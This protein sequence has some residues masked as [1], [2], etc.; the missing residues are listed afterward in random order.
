MNIANGPCRN[1]HRLIRPRGNGQRAELPADQARLRRQGN[2][3]QQRPGS[4]VCLRDNLSNGPLQRLPEGIDPHVELLVQFHPRHQRLGH[5]RVQLRLGGG[6]NDKQGLAR[7][8][9]VTGIDGFTDQAPAERGLNGGVTQH[10][11][12]LANRRDRLLLLG[13]QAGG[14]AA[15]G[16]HLLDRRL[17]AFAHGGPQVGSFLR[18]VGVPVH[19]QG[20][21]AKSRDRSA[22]MRPG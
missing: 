13:L 4:R 20:F 12:R 6:L 1:H 7:H 16:C 3:D 2:L 15:D 17:G 9:H 21:S 18:C 14:I 8:D 10:D 5:D 19:G 22:P 11:L